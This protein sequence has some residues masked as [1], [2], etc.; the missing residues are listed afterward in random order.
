[1][2]EPIPGC[3]IL[4]NEEN[5]ILVRGPNVM[6]GYFRDQ[7]RTSDVIDGYGWFNTGDI[8]E[9]TDY[10]LRLIGRID[11]QFKLSNGEKVSSTLVESALTSPSK[12]VQHAVALGAGEDYVAALIFPNFKNLESWAR[13]HGKP[14]ADK[15]AL[16]GDEEVQ[17]LISGEITGNMADFGSKVMTV[18]GFAIIPEELSMERGELTPSL[19]IIRH[20]VI[21][22]Y[23]EWREAIYQESGHIDKKRYVVKVEEYDAFT[24]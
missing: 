11:G 21:A 18:R 23:K 10:G 19:K 16:V 1:V 15:P 13:D 2:G 24:W 8:G 4:T 9:I 6:A 17:N 7:E 20:R 3:E 22:K 14:Y 5:E 12:W